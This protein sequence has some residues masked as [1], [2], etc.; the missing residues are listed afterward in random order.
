M[1]SKESTKQE[2]KEKKEKKEIEQQ[3][4]QPLMKLGRKID[5]QKKAKYKE[6]PNRSNLRK[7]QEI[8]NMDGEILK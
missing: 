7:A 5:Q 3:S 1:L 8:T 2:K 6:F 4:E